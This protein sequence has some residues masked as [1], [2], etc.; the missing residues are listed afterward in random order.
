MPNKL[1]VNLSNSSNPVPGKTAHFCDTARHIFYNS[2]FLGLKLLRYNFAWLRLISENVSSIT[3]L[4]L[5]G[6]IFFFIDAYHLWKLQYS[7]ST[8]PGKNRYSMINYIFPHQFQYHIRVLYL[9]HI[10]NLFLFR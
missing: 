10:E 5:Y 4:R 6:C 1:P 2:F 8:N 7:F 9:F 3:L